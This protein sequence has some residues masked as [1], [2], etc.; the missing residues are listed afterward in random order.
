MTKGWPVEGLGL[1]REQEA[2]GIGANSR[3]GAT[4]EKPLPSP[5]L[6]K[7]SA[8]FRRSG[9]AA[10]ANYLQGDLA[11]QPQREV[12]SFLACHS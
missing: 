1:S 10:S 4:K 3:I 2:A 6:F 7:P 12:F 8:C 9:K 5:C 11:K